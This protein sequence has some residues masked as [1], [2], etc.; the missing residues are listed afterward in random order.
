MSNKKTII[1]CA[2]VIFAI[3][4]AAL[5]T[6]A[7]N[8][9]NSNHS[10][11][12]R[13]LPTVN[14]DEEQTTVDFDDEIITQTTT[15]KTTKKAQT[16]YSSIESDLK[17]YAFSFEGAKMKFRQSGKRIYYADDDDDA[18]AVYRFNPDES[19]SE[20]HLD[21][22]EAASY[23]DTFRTFVKL[24]EKGVI[25]EYCSEDALEGNQI[26]DY[27]FFASTYKG[28]KEFSERV[29]E[30]SNEFDGERVYILNSEDSSVETV[31]IKGSE[32]REYR[33]KGYMYFPQAL[34]EYYLE[35]VFTA[36]GRAFGIFC[37]GKDY[38]KYQL[39]YLKDGNKAQIISEISTN[40]YIAG[41][42][43]YYCKDGM[44]YMIDLKSD[45]FKP[46]EIVKLNCD[47]LYF[48]TKDRVYFCKY[49]NKSAEIYYYSFAAK[50][51]YKITA[52]SRKLNEY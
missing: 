30:Y 34:K 48:V 37:G 8:R 38:D 26:P 25:V 10:K 29:N 22:T 51:N 12:G 39:V 6:V 27:Y 52:S 44:L 9:N 32:S 49:N 35:Q 43:F 18:S 45:A 2:V 19:D 11:T 40:Y 16:D 42:E 5:G 46:K 31:K 33:F 36:N 15:Q 41:K 28:K 1:I 21:I 13:M 7:V 50:S 3:V 20:K 14:P 17:R 23:G 47:V 24:C 4:A